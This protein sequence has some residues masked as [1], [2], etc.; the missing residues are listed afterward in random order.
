MFSSYFCVLEVFV[1]DDLVR[2]HGII[3]IKFSFDKVIIVVMILVILDYYIARV[4][5]LFTCLLIDL[6]LLLD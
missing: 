1:C 3:I 4:A 5:G 2:A 6:S